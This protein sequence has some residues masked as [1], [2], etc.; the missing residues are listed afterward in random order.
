MA[1]LKL[2]KFMLSEAANKSLSRIMA[3]AQGRNVGIITAHRGEHDKATNNA[4][5]KDLAHDIRKAGLGFVHVKGR[6]VE[7]YGK[8]EARHVDE[9]SYFVMGKKGNDS[10]HLKGFLKHHGEKYGQDSVLHKPHDSENAHLIGTKEGGYPGHG[11]TADLGKF[12]ANR[13]PEF[14]SVLKGNRTFAFQEEA[15]EEFGIYN[16]ISF[17]SRVETPY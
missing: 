7:N 10:G 4:R 2:R 17:S 9:H 6:Y 16:P 13:I 15:W 5:N 3:H 12:H 8:P 1:L 11:K 14:H